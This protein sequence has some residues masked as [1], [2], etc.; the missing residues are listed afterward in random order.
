MGK[1][2]REKNGEGGNAG[3]MEED[4]EDVRTKRTAIGGDKNQNHQ[5]ENK[6]RNSA[7]SE[8][9]DED[10]PISRIRRRSRGMTIFFSFLLREIAISKSPSHFFCWVSSIHLP[11]PCSH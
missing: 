4:G 6:G 8:E 3:V 11:L 1:N 9:V 7:P 2:E 5:F 10:F